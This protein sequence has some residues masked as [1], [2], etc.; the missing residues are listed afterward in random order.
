MDDVLE[1]L[2]GEGQAIWTV[3]RSSTLMKL[4]YH[5]G[6]CYPSDIA[7][8]ACA[9]DHLLFKMLEKATGLSIPR[10][11]QGRGVECCTH[12]P[13]DRLHD[14]SYQDWMVRQ[15][16]R[17]GGMGMRS[18][19]DV[20]L[21]AFCGSVEQALPHFVGIDGVCKQLGPTIGEM[22]DTGT[23]WRD[24]MASGC[25]TGLE[26]E[27]A[28]SVLREEARQS[29]EFLEQDLSGPLLAGVEGAGDGCV[30]GSTRR[31][32]TTWLE[33]CRASVLKKALEHHPDQSARPVWVNPQLDKLSQGWILSLPGPEGFSHAEFSETVAKQLCLPSPCCQPRIGTPLGQHGMNVDSFGDNLMSV[34]NIPGDSFRHRHD[35]VKTVLNRFC[36]T[37]SIKAECEVFGVFRDLIPVQALGEGGLERGRGRQGLL[38]DFQMELPTSQGQATNQLAELKVI[39]AAGSCYPRSGPSARRTRGVERRASRLTGEYRRPLENLDRRHHGVSD[40]QTGPLVRRLES[41]G[42]L[43]GLVVGAFQE[44]SKDLHSLLGTMAD[45]QLRA[46]GL[47]RGR[48]GTDQERSIILAGLRRV[49]SMTAAKAH[50][51]CL[52]DRVARVGECHRQAAK[53]RAWMKREE[54]RMQEE[55]AHFWHANV[56]TRGLTRGQFAIQ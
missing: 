25:R 15:P 45:S 51:S 32:I 7:E 33:D 40:G 3:L 19:V 47:A 11:E 56:R 30:D 29:S 2:D 18:M 31:L 26:M 41:F 16:V 23:R 48:Q 6:L 37:S 54:E 10:L 12:V 21:A 1:V 46:R 39:G 49:L 24:L 42:P 14:K 43:I 50:S 9:L 53:R 55:R 52:M 27:Y 35:K 5:L 28:W 8:A 36:L 17:L 22:R 20:S 13:V 38:P 4:D 34:T 44:G